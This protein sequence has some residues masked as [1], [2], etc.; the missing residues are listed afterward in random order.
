MCLRVKRRNI[1]LNGKRHPLFDSFLFCAD[2]RTEQKTILPFLPDLNFPYWENTK[3]T[4]SRASA[5]SAWWSG[6][7]STAC[8]PITYWG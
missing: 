6:Q 4:I 8:P 1:N 3:P 5:R 7:S 2:N